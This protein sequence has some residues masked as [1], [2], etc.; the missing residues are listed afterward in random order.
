MFLAPTY[1]TGLADAETQ[2][3]LALER[4][5]VNHSFPGP[6]T[7]AKRGNH[8]MTLKVSENLQSL[9]E[10]A[11]RTAALAYLSVEDFAQ[12]RIYCDLAIKLT[13]SKGRTIYVS[14]KYA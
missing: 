7:I 11:Y 2:A 3:I 5:L 14:D 12:A 1:Q 8:L 6:E 13:A 10:Q 9:V 4:L